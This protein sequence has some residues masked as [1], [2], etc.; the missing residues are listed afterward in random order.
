MR[1]SVRFYKRLAPGLSVSLSRRGL[2][3]S[4]TVPGSGLYVSQAWGRPGRAPARA[5]HGSGLGTVFLFG[6][7]WLVLGWKFIAGAVLLA[8]V[9]AIISAWIGRSHQAK[10]EVV[11]DNKNDQIERLT[12]IGKRIEFLATKGQPLARYVEQHPDDQAAAAESAELASELR[13]L[14][15]E[16][17]VLSRATGDRRI[18]DAARAIFA[19]LPASPEFARLLERPARLWDASRLS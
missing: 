10:E 19:A 6:L 7:L 12:R 2:R 4:E 1:T 15:T 9:F 8:V 18:I 11:M 13:S 3:T 5:H 14:V 17:E 16:C